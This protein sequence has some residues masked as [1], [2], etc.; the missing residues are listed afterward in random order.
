VSAWIEASDIGYRVG[1]ATL[2]ESVDVTLAGGELVAV[3]GPNGAGKS[4]LLRLLAGDLRPTS[5]KVML[6]DE[7]LE[8]YD[9]DELALQRGVF[10]QQSVR[11]IPFTVAAV[12]AMGR[13]PHQRRTDSSSEDDRNAVVAALEKTE[14]SH[15]A[16]RVFAT[17][18]SG[19]QTRVSLARVFA[20]DTPV[21]LLDEPTTALDVAHGERVMSE[22]RRLA[23]RDRA[24]LAV[25]HD[26]NAAAGYATRVV[27]VANGTILANGTPAEVFEERLLSDVYGQPMRVVDHPFRD[28]P[29]ILVT[30]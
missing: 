23:D 7:P 18:S 6:A 10:V 24:V 11:D 22:L 4:T 25:L 16:E 3:V 17:L 29:L 19:E 13:Y 26:L 5:G 27:V 14:T 30:D 20:Q 8:H 12:V 21:L 28:C 1:K 15:L 2:L 9:Y